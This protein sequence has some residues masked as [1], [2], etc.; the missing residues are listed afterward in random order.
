MSKVKMK[1]TNNIKGF[2]LV[3]IL[4]VTLIVLTV[5]LLTANVYRTV[6]R[7][8]L[9]QGEAINISSRLEQIRSLAEAQ[10]SISGGYGIEYRLRFVSGNPCTVIGEY[11]NAST[12]TWVT[13]PEFSNIAIPLSQRISFGVTTG[14]T[15][16]PTDQPTGTPTSA[17]EI[18]F[19]SRGFPVN[20]SSNPPTAPKESNAIY[21][22][23][24]TTN[25]AIT[26]NILGRIQVWAY[27]RGGSNLWVPITGSGR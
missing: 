21:I 7:R 9:V 22:N 6:S 4:V 2:T 5:A 27:D 18:R 8:N 16:S 20:T 26:V 3:E 12:T 1:N 13:A 19:N 15:N 23:D 17:T 25:Y 24:G 14:V 10:K 11:Y